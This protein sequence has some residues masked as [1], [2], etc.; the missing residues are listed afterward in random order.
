MAVAN[1]RGVVDV[2]EQIQVGPGDLRVVSVR[3]RRGDDAIGVYGFV[4][5]YRP[6]ELLLPP[7]GQRLR[8]ARRRVDDD[9]LV[10]G[11]REHLPRVAAV[12]RQRCADRGLPEVRQVVGDAQ[13]RSRWHVADA[14]EV[15]VQPSLHGRH[16][17]E[18]AGH[19]L[20]VVQKRAAGRVAGHVVDDDLALCQHAVKTP[21]VQVACANKRRHQ[22]PITSYVFNYC[23]ISE[24]F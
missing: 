12:E 15:F 24:H 4:P 14:V 18:A 10:G 20:V 6:L 9:D 16:E 7:I 1:V 5:D 19:H 22:Q 2:F 11:G 21:Q 17:R 3:A 23:L 8:S 13:R